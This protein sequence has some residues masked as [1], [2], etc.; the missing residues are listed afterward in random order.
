MFKRKT[1]LIATILVLLGILSPTSG[2]VTVP[3]FRKSS[4]EEVVRAMTLEEKVSLLVGMGM[5]LGIPGMVFMSPEDKLLPEK[6]P[7]AAGRTHPILRLG[8]PSIALSD[9]PA[10]VRINPTRDGQPGKTFHATG[11]PVATLLAS[12]WDTALV[13]QVG[14]AFGSE[15]RDFGVD[16][17]LAPGMNLHRN[18]LGGRNFEYYSEDPLL[19]GKMA[20]AF[21]NGVQS[22]GVGT[23]I[24]HFAVNSQEFNRMQSNS[25]VSERALRELYLRGFE[26][27]VKESSPWTVMSSYNLINGTYTSQSQDLLITILRNEWKYNGVVMTDWFAGNDVVAQ[28]KARNEIIMPGVPAQAAA[29]IAAVKSG[30]LEEKLLDQNV[31]STLR[32]IERTLAAKDFKFSS[33]PDLKLHSS[34]VRKA[35]AEGMVL[36]K[37]DSS[38][39]FQQGAKVGLFG[40]NAYDL[41][42]GGTGSGDVNKAY[43]ISLDKGLADAG[44]G[45]DGSLQ[46]TYR[47]YI[48]KAKAARPQVPWY[49]TPPPIA[50]M[51]LSET[52]VESIAAGSDV[53]V[54]V[55]GRN[56]GEFADRKVAGDFD[57]TERESA[58]IGKLSNA[59][60]SKSKKLV[61]VLNI[62][63]PI[64]TASW[65]D[66]VDA[67]LL[68]WLPGQEAGYSIA[69]ILRGIVNP[70]G[71]LPMTFPM[72]YADV[73]SSD[74][75]P[76]RE[77]SI[78]PLMTGN[79][80][81]GK[82]A[83][84]IYSEGIFVGYRYYSTQNVETAYE[85]GYG[86]SY[87]DFSYENLKLEGRDLSPVVKVGVKNTGKVAGREVVQLYVSA[88]NGTLKKPLTELR[89][90]GKT[91]Q[92]RPG[93]SQ[94]LTF[95][96]TQRDLASFD[97]TRS[98]WVIEPGRYCLRLQSSARLVRLSKCVDIKDLI[99]VEK[100]N[101]VLKP[102]GKIAE[103]AYVR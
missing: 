3:K 34:V 98:A 52:T 72:K 31:L 27:A 50:E 78:P 66:K 73:P 95:S 48:A 68:A 11:F 5:D 56:S 24:K 83:E 91:R 62:G 26:I 49:L 30:E 8:I 86:H 57:L 101:P 40:N 4:L 29:I 41:I 92:L 6:V 80:F 10:G 46:K 58:N 17:L 23:S 84:A 87:T 45:I 19:T 12:S 16:V 60:R 74:V 89:A 1:T 93:E 99:E 55:I 9:G 43:V 13:R 53:G 42:A 64:E 90:F 71:R 88:P 82:P 85:F 94:T 75:F 22:K 36:L 33:T 51:E 61:A 21:V 70:S 77:L 25:I 54:I 96:L 47:D 100:V 63:G 69:D 59:F 37:N 76:G 15:A 20:A 2:Q 32:L 102:Q 97:P 44:F 79:P 35:A 103:K 65:R 18:P 7:G 39:P 81:V 14:E 38:L 67:I 28:M